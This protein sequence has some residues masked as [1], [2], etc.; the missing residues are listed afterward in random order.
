M[1]KL[2]FTSKVTVSIIQHEHD[3]VQDRLVALH[4]TW[5]DNWHQIDVN[6]RILT[7]Y[8]AIMVD[9]I[10]MWTLEDL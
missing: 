3:G 5:Y 10:Y 8:L 6:T 2:E 9:I 1:L 4:R 7:H